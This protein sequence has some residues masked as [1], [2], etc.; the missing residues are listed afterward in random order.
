[1]NELTLHTGNRTELLLDELAET[2]ASSPLPPLVPEIVVVQSPGMERYLSMSLARLRGI[3]ANIDFPFP[4]S[5]ITRLLRTFFPQLPQ[6]P[7]WEPEILAWRLMQELPALLQ[8]PAFTRPASYAGDGSDPVRTYR[9]CARLADLFDQYAVF[10]PDMIAQWRSGRD[11][12]E[13]DERWQAELWRRTAGAAAWGNR[14]ALFERLLDEVRRGRLPEN[15]LPPRVC[16]FGIPALPP[17]YLTLLRA[18][19]PFIDIHLFVLNPSLHF[20]DDIVSEKRAAATAADDSRAP[21]LLHLD[22]GNPLPASLGDQGREFFGQL[23]DTEPRELSRFEKPGE[24]CLLHMIQSDILELRTRETP[25]TIRDDDHSVQVHSCHSPL[26][27]V[28]VLYDNLLDLFDRG[29]GLSPSDIV[30]MTPDIET[31]APFVQAVFDYP[32][33]GCPRLPYSIAD[34]SVRADHRTVDDFLLLLDL[35][36]HHFPADEVLS[37]LQSPSVRT[38]LGLT[39]EDMSV[40]NQWV[41]SA[42]I[43]W[44]MDAGDRED[45]GVPPTVENTWAWGMERVVLGYA[46][47]PEGLELFDGRLPV[48]HIDENRGDLLGTLVGFVDSLQHRARELSVPRTL[49]QWTSCLLSLLDE[50]FAP[51]DASE[52]DLHRIRS[53]ITDL[54]L[55]AKCAGYDAEVRPEVVRHILRDLPTRYGSAAGFL[56]GGITFCTMLPMRSIPFKVLWLMGMDEGGFPR[57]DFPAAFDRIGAAPRAGDRSRRKSDKYLFLE[58]LLSAREVLSISYVGQSP[59]DNAELPPSTLVSELLDYIQR[60]FRPE[61]ASARDT[62]RTRRHVVVRHRLTPYH[63]D[64]ISGDTASSRLFSY[65]REHRDTARA[66][67]GERSDPRPFIPGPLAGETP[68]SDAPIALEDLVSFLSRPSRYFLR[69]TLGITLPE[70]IQAAP[71]EEPLVSEGLDLYTLKRLLTDAFRTGVSGSRLY[72]AVAASGQ[73]P[74][75]AVGRSFF[76]DAAAPARFVDSL[77][78]S[79]AGE[80]RGPSFMDLEA[81]AGRWNVVGRVRHVHGGRIVKYRPARIKA[82]DRIRMWVTHLLTNAAREPGLPREGILIG[83]NTGTSSKGG[84]AGA[85]MLRYTP[86]ADAAEILGDLCG[87]YHEVSRRAVPFFPETSLAYAE[88]RIGKDAA[89]QQAMRAAHACW[90]GNAF[91]KGESADPWNALCRRDAEPLGASFQETALRIFAPMLEH[92]QWEGPA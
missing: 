90:E 80:P 47:E 15:S 45:A 12:G 62:T 66:L 36:M 43:N 30:V 76:E 8:Q 56:R 38:R 70:T 1:M 74:H 83:V 3:S 61:H 27:E 28:Q 16:F 84:V 17:L 18:L 54:R 53:A 9:L 24:G 82:V 75:G 91:R 11:G 49:D 29:A 79:H 25:G 39:E 86:V 40:V 34:R 87:L 26:R 41:E 13:P 52:K 73:L 65:V 35:P 23:H 81:R 42:R 37:L 46:M 57:R 22:T 88:Q 67:Q 20:W 14:V 85:D 71:S 4:N 6:R 68:S 64:Y 58:S 89:E 19:A 55:R 59:V 33:Q 92:E 21:E 2:L 69:T 72:R 31:Y 32:P 48:E 78:R 10:R 77:V 63:P 51:D 7:P 44:G 5:F 60:F 50:F